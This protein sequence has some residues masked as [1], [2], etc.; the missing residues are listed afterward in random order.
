MRTQLPKLLSILIATAA[1]Q[2]NSAEIHDLLS[3]SEQPETTAK[4]GPMREDYN[5][6]MGQI[7]HAFDYGESEPN[8]TVLRRIWSPNNSIAIRLRKNIGTLISIPEG[9]RI[10]GFVLGDQEGFIPKLLGEKMPNKIV[11][12]PTA[13]EIDTNLTLID[14]NNR[15]YTFYLRSDP[16]ESNIVPHFSVMVTLPGDNSAQL[17]PTTDLKNLNLL[18]NTNQIF[19][20]AATDIKIAKDKAILKKLNQK[21]YDFLQ[22][23]EASG[24]VNKD[25][26]MYGN[27]EIAPNAVWDDGKQVYI[28]FRDGTPSSRLPTLYRIIDGYAT[29][30]NSHYRDG[31]LIT[32]SVSFEG[33]MLLD[34]SKTV[35]IKMHAATKS[36]AKK[37]KIIAN[38]NSTIKAKKINNLS[39]SEEAAL[40]LDKNYKESK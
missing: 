15:L 13:Y 34:G 25:Y 8:D 4:A 22:I 20:A 37:A 29:I 23:L 3:N 12:S 31:F 38:N 9:E 7:I 24:P 27:S 17:N 1:W 35:C 36:A 2:A 10:Q 6:N 16:K 5:I 14:E 30:A 18:A 21:E 26:S 11:I 39:L 40:L 33:W 28:S 32:D 19:P